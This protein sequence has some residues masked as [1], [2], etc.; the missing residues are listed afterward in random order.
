MWFHAS[1]ALMI[2]GRDKDNALWNEIHGKRTS[3]YKKPM[4]N[5][6]KAEQERRPYDMNISLVWY[7]QTHN[8]C[9][10]FN[11]KPIHKR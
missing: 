4:D 2:H 10:P 8:L 11:T 3:D 1:E 9:F 5:E 6:E 7:A